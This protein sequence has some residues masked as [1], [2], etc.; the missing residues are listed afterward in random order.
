MLLLY[1]RN[2]KYTYNFT[3]ISE[4][5]KVMF[6]ENGELIPAYQVFDADGKFAIHNYI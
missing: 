2:I 3:L 5:A 4:K 1:L 6:D